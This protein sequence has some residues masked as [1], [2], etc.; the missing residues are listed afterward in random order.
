[1][2]PILGIDFLA[3]F[4]LVVDLENRKIV[5]SYT[6]VNGSLVVC[7]VRPCLE[8]LDQRIQN[9]I[10]KYPSITN[11]S[12]MNKNTAVAKV[13]HDID[14]GSSSPVYCRAR[15]LS[16]EKLNAAREEFKFMLQ[17]GIVRRSNS[18]WSSPLHM[19]KK[20]D[21]SW[22]PC[23]DYRSLNNIIISDKYPVPNLRSLTT[24]FYGK[25]IFSK[26]DLKRAFL[27]IPVSEKDIPKTAVCTP[28]GLFEYLKMPFGLKNFGSTFQ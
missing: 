20:S 15:S 23:G 22:R 2:K 24:S 11:P 25:C 5:D 3:N 8:R 27:Q 16:G 19:V 21:N 10:E 17:S 26:I 13:H 28:F 4:S 1:M 6:K 14:T 7:S 12:K 9:I 18:P